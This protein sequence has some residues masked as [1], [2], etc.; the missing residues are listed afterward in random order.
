MLKI[1]FYNPNEKISKK[2]LP[3]ITQLDIKCISVNSR[4]IV[5]RVKTL[6][7]T[8]IPTLYCRNDNDIRI[9]IGDE[10]IHFLD[11]VN[12]AQQTEVID[13]GNNE[14]TSEIG[15]V[16]VL[17]ASRPEPREDSEEEIDVSKLLK[18]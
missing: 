18:K 15:S 10:I 1:F 5:D 11:S 16:E 9:L 8:R 13:H 12:S 6:G 7:I 2:C 3:G 17:E 4:K 14:E